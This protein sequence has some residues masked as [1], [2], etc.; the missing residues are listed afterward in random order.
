MP[1]RSKGPH[2]WFRKARRDSSG[3][4]VAQGVWLIIDGRK[5]IATG[6]VEGQDTRAHQSLSA[7]IAEKY[8]PQRARRALED[9]TVADVL[10]V[11][12]A[13][14]KAPGRK[15][16]ARV[17]RLNEFWGRTPLAEVTGS[18][19][20]EYAALRATTGA[21]RELEDL[22]AAINHHAKEGY[23]REPVLVTLPPRGQARDRWL[24]RLEAAK[25]LRVCWRWREVQA[26]A[27]G[28]VLTPKYPLRHLA[29]FLLIGLYTGT[30]AGAIA[31][32][33][34]K[35]EEGRSFVDLDRGIF[36]RLA[37]GK[38]ETNKRQTPA[39]IPKRLLAHMRRW[40]RLGIVKEH[41]VEWNGR[42]VKSVKTAFASAVD[43]ADIGHASPHTLRH[44]AATWMMQNGA[45]LWEAAGFLGMSEKTLRDVYGHHSPD[46]MGGAAKAVTAKAPTN[47]VLVVSL[48]ERRERRPA[49]GVSG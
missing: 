37:V 45:P 43:K 11:Y 12:L 17:G 23:H 24:T 22:R 36:Y 14:T 47:D 21:R 9:I 28:P 40:Q 34:P 10:A 25:L 48:V 13:D 41:F 38:A 20:R 2:L 30:R 33:S 35:R 1:A 44:T 42:P 19:C 6:C 5:H 8:T 27:K 18:A 32:A 29:R 46:H 39:P 26:H 3:E 49:V 7:Y 4:V 31:T 15:F 16:M